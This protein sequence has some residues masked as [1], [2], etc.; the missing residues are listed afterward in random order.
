MAW[1]SWSGGLPPS[2]GSGAGG[3]GEAPARICTPGAVTSGFRYIPPGPREEKAAI[4]SPCPFAR[5][6]VV[7]EPVT[8][9]CAFMNATNWVPSARCTV[10]SQWLSVSLSAC[11]GL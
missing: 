4:T 8:E 7:N 10:G 1:K 5:R 6:A 9:L 2:T 11:V 3:V